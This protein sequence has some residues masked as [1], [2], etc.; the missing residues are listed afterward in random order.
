MSK[1]T[2]NNPSEIGAEISEKLCA[3]TREGVRNA[4]LVLPSG[5]ITKFPLS[6]GAE[7]EQAVDIGELRKETGVIT[8]DPGFRNTGACQSAIT[9]VDGEKGV[10]RYRGYP[11]E[12]LAKDSGFIETAMLLIWGELPNKK[13]RAEF[14]EMLTNNEMLHE[15]LKPHFDAFPPNGKPMA[16]LSVVLASMRGYEP[17]LTEIK[18]DKNFKP[19]V[20]KIMSQVRTIAANIHNKTKGSPWQYP[21]PDFGYCQN[22]LHMLHSIPNKPYHPSET[23]I[24]ALETFFILHADHEQ[25]CSTS[26][27]RIVG[28]AKSDLFA[29]ISA[30]VN[31]LNGKLHGGANAAVIRQL[32]GILMSKKGFDEI[33]AKAKT[34]PDFR[35]MGFGHAVY[36]N[37]DPRAKILK[38]VAEKLLEELKISDPVFDLAKKLE[39]VALDD[40]YFISR[41]L[42]PNVDFYSGIILKALKIPTN[43][44]PVIFA[45]GRM[46]GWIA[47]WREQYLDE[48]TKIA[49]PRQ[50]YTGHTK[51]EY[52]SAKDR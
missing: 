27:V 6:V 14:R 15:G 37:Y 8:L 49:R 34:N 3:D 35:L 19:L 33:I 9:F 32:E 38:S 5:Q 2:L 48:S 46:P 47:H 13:E 41:N 26:T 16:L 50:I 28:S 31:A 11:I 12:Q 51:R 1:Q 18:S 22:F 40:E 45:I 24:K 21:N 20:A 39:Q 17:K 36:K 25:N 52:V 43:M 7:G 44:F 23:E 30:G 29:S 42:Y 10:L 4:Y